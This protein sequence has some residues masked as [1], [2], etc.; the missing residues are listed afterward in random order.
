VSDLRIQPNAVVH[1]VNRCQEV[2]RRVAG[3]LIQEKKAKVAEG[4]RIGKS[5]AGRDLLT[6]LCTLF[7][8]R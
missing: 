2:I 7:M 4:E 1:T 8:P 3:K 5:F 6:L